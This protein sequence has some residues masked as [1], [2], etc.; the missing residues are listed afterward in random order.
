M[1]A[2][3]Q[4]L[5]ITAVD[6]CPIANSP[7]DPIQT[8]DKKESDHEKS[9]H[10][11]VESCIAS[12]KDSVGLWDSIYWHRWFVVERIEVLIKDTGFD[13]TCSSFTPQK[14]SQGLLLHAFSDPIG[15]PFT[16]GFHETSAQ[17]KMVAN[18]DYDQFA[19]LF[20]SY[21]LLVEVKT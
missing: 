9:K 13:Y 3:L 6:L 14:Y 20:Q 16:K 21:E 15:E 10:P 4:Q 19:F 7:L 17:E 1:D 12:I 5:W 11:S 18:T 8:L 2:I